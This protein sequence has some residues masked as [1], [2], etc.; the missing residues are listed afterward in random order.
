MV[1]GNL[2]V[3][4][5]FVLQPL[6]SDCRQANRKRLTAFEDAPELRTAHLIGYHLND[7]IIPRGEPNWKSYYRA[8]ANLTLGQLCPPRLPAILATQIPRRRSCSMIPLISI[9]PISLSNG[10]RVVCRTGK[11]PYAL[12]G[13]TVTDQVLRETGIAK[14]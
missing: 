12:S 9:S 14:I 10:L 5:S 4:T 3:L 8:P 6:L 11:V 1:K 7:A 13:L 2:P